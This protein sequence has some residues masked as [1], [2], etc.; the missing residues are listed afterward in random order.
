M[1]GSADADDRRSDAPRDFGRNRFHHALDDDAKGPRI[2]NCLGIRNDLFGLAILAAARAVAAQ[3][4]H[5]L[6]RETDVAM[7]GIPR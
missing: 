5:S 6:G 1:G 3:D 4:I 2:G 7:T